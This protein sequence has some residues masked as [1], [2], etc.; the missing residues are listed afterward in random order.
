MSRADL[1][2]VNVNL[3]D[4]CVIL[5]AKVTLIK[6]LIK[7]MKSKFVRVFFDLCFL[8]RFLPMMIQHWRTRKQSS[9]HSTSRP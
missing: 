6:L 9:P 1:R 5:S 4:M 7:I 8:F 2:A 3:C